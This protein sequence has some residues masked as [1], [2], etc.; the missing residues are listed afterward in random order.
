MKRFK[1]EKVKAVGCDDLIASAAFQNGLR[2]DNPLFGE[3]I[4][5]E[6]LIMAD[7]FALAKKYAFWDEA[8]GADKASEQPRKEL[9]VAQKK[10]EGNQYNNKSMQGAKRRNRSSIKGGPMPKNYY[11]FSILIH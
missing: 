9:T 7:F 6:D 1:V 10:E 3:L 5:K 11:K 8:R 2:T 4:M